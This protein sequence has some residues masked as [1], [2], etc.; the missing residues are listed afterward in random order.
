MGG[1]ALFILGFTEDAAV[2]ELTVAAVV[3][4]EGAHARTQTVLWVHNSP[5]GTRM[6]LWDLLDAMP[7]QVRVADVNVPLRPTLASTFASIRNIRTAARSVSVVH[8]QFGSLVGLLASLTS[9]PL[10]L[11]LRGTDFYVMPSTTLAGWIE[12]RLR[13]AF[14]YVACLRATVVIVMSK[15]MRRELRKWPLLRGKRIVVITDPVGAE[16]LGED[17][18]TCST[19]A[20]AEAVPFRVFVGSLSASNPV[21]RTWIVERAVK[22]CSAVGLPVELKVMS[23]VPRSQVLSEMRT[24]DLVALTSTHEGWPNIVKE[25]RACGLPFIATDV[26][27]LTELCGPDTPNRIVEPNHLDVAL[28]MVDSLARREYPGEGSDTLPGVVGVKHHILY[29]HIVRSSL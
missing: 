17:A 3:G 20:L 26:S 23:G 5:K 25:G 4:A 15:R 9:R 12:G 27:D 14:T 1:G 21:K 6:F 13:Q 8:A 24:S 18:R 22:L 11:S 16:F 29:D 28:A 2:D 10:V 19:T 7:P